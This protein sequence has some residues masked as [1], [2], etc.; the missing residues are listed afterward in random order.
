MTEETSG[1]SVDRHDLHPQIKRNLVIIA[2]LFIVAVALVPIPKS[3]VDR[4]Y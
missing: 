2:A 4:C 3:V 1:S